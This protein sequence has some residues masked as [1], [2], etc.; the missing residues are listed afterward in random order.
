MQDEFLRARIR[1]SIA[2]LGAMMGEQKPFEEY[3]EATLGVTPKLVGE[4]Y[5]TPIQNNIESCLARFGLIYRR[6]NLPAFETSL[7]LKDPN[8]IVNGFLA[9]NDLLDRCAPPSRHICAASFWLRSQG[10]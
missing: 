10:G 4:E 3:I 7:V 8:Q 2:Y 9:D 6:D 1:G 5:L